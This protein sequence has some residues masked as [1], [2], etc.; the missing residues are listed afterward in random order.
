VT[1]ALRTPAWRISITFALS[2]MIHAAILWLP[3]ARAPQTLHLPPLTVRLELSPLPAVQPSKTPGPVKQAGKPGGSALGKPIS[4]AAAPMKEMNKST[5]AHQFPKHLQLVFAVYN[6]AGGYRIG[7]LYHQLDIHEDRYTLRATK[8]ITGLASLLNS[9]DQFIQIS[10]GKV[11]DRGLHPETFEEERIAGSGK[12]DKK[13]T[14]DWATQK[15]R[16]THGDE[17]AL[18]ADAQD[19]LSFTYQ[20]SQLSMHA[21]MLVLPI[22][23]GTQLEQITIEIGAIEEIP[24]PMGMIR[25]RHLRKWH[26]QGEAY[27]EIWL[28]LEY[29]LLPVKIRQVDGSGEITEEAV[30]SAIRASD[31]DSP[32]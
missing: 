27:F 9:N 23:G 19:I 16:F 7:E 15:L 10:Y 17:A 32:M 25:A 29:S 28:G 11:D 31:E 8:Q 30:V 14:F 21:E 26:A 3:S 12:Q 24:T 6:G 5:A 22:G 20:L 1:A 18:P 2:A 13:V 4:S